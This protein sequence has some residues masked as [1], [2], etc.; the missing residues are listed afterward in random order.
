M[1]LDKR[2]LINASFNVCEVKLLY[3]YTVS[4][5]DLLYFNIRFNFLI[6]LFLYIFLMLCIRPLENQT[7]YILKDYRMH[8]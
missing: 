1:Y 8:T 7:F 5:P 3:K 4:V 6:L 2:R